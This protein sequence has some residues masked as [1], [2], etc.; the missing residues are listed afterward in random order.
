MKI[1]YIVLISCLVLF[2]LDSQSDSLQ[3]T[4]DSKSKAVFEGNPLRDSKGQI[5]SAFDKEHFPIYGIHKKLELT[6]TDCH[7]EKN[8]QDYSSAM[9]RSCEKCHGDSKTLAD[10]TSGLGHN[11]NIHQSPH[12]ESL[13]CDICHKSHTDVSAVENPNTRQKV[14]CA[15]CHGQESMQKLIAR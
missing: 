11:N 6:C 4:E 7:L 12:Y 3:P 1:L 5:P 10:Y 14:L 2:G 9:N 8:P 13:D 15:Q